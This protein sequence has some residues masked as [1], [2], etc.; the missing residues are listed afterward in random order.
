MQSV[1]ERFL[2][3]VKYHTTSDPRSVS[4]PSTKEQLS[5]AAFLAKECEQIGLTEISV[6]KYGYL[7]AT[8]PA[9]AEGP[10][11]GF[12][13]HMDTSPDAPG[14]QVH[15]NIVEHYDGRVIPLNGLSLSAEE[16]PSLLQYKGETLI[17]SDGT[18]LLG[19]DDK[20]GIAEILSAM[21]YLSLHPEIPHGKIRIAFTPDEEIG[22]GVDHFDVSAFGADFAYTMD[23]GEIGELQYENFNAAAA[24][25][26]IEGKSVH[27]GSAKNAMVNA[28]SVGIEIA[29]LVP[30]RET[31]EKTEGYEGFFHLHD[32]NGS[33]SHATMSYIIRDFNPQTF[34]NRKN[35]LRMI[36]D[37]KNIQYK[38]A[39]VLNLYDQY[40]NM[41]SQLN[42]YP[43]IIDLAKRAL[44]QCGVTPIVRP[45]RGGTDGARLSF[46]G[47]P[48]PNLFTGGHNFHGPYEYIPIS[49]ME[50][51]VAVIVK[52]AELSVGLDFPKT[53]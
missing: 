14:K 36:I 24:E 1:S 20:A 51:A 5:F 48:C 33:V 49:S 23:G 3:Y 4:F 50:K 30:E 35:L 39:I 28:I 11:I 47:L 44:E 52:I 6:D 27:P 45:I 9:T 41:A 21:E 25:I 10:T 42:A 15:P 29:S 17:T 19:A 31:P 7:F 22:H 13:A 2:T 38:N 8:L 16:F 43:E 53:V 32:F 40:Y 34:E 37:R 12:I 18:T 26:T 46:M